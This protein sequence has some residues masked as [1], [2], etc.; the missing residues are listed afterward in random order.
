VDASFFMLYAN[1]YKRI[2]QEIDCSFL[3]S[4]KNAFL[5]SVIGLL[6][7]VDYPITKY[8]ISNAS[9]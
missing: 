3:W 7:A 5:V 9:G 6:K 8:E 4:D 2:K 1:V